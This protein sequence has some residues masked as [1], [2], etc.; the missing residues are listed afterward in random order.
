MRAIK[1]FEQNLFSSWVDGIKRAMQ[2][3]NQKQKFEMSGQLMEF[4]ME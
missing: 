4:D 3:Q 1:D 2:D